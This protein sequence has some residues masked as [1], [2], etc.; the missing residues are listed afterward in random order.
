MSKTS[1]ELERICTNCNSSF[2]S[3]PYGS[4]FAI[5]LNDP[6]FE[7][8]LDDLLENQDFSRC[9]ELVRQKRFPW[10]Q[11]AC[12]DFD[13][14]DITDEDTS[15]ICHLR[16]QWSRPISESPFSGKSSTRANLNRILRSSW[17]KTFP[18]PHPTIQHG[19]GTLRYS[20][21]LK[22][23]HRILRKRHSCQ[24]WIRLN[25]PIASRSGSK[26]S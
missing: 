21:S 20:A 4:D 26:E 11:E 23:R 2:P 6:E 15:R 1:D 25:F 13:P 22:A 17:W 18:G 12:P 8:Y 5:C 19:V 10:E 9:Q 14:V 3:E 16:R 7:P 24:C